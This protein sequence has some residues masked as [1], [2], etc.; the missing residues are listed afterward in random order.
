VIDIR[1]NIP[2]APYSTLHIGGLADYFVI[3][4]Q[5]NDLL[6][7]LHWANDNQIPFVVIGY[8]SNILFADKGF[9]GLVIINRINNFLIKDN[10]VLV[11][12]GQTLSGIARETI[13]RGLIGLHF[14]ANIP[15]TIGGAIVGNAGTLGWDIS[16]TLVSA[17]I[18]HDGK[19]RIWQNKDFDFSY[20]ESKLKDKNE[21]VILSAEFELTDGRMGELENQIGEDMKRRLQS[22][23]GKTCGSYFKN[24]QGKVAGKLIDSLNLKGY[25]IGDA[26]VSPL[27]ANVF[28]N[29]GKANSSDIFALEKYVRDK[30]Y[31]KYKIYLEPEIVKIGF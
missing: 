19:V 5:K 22:Y 17:E 9:R 21:Q 13:G 26:E 25:R 20:R 1:K 10:R 29:V 31:E 12:S 15:G 16:K 24:P 23:K 7:A 30:V 2:L 6:S 8:G 27:H 28:R 3:C 14:G 18:W 11:E 4:K